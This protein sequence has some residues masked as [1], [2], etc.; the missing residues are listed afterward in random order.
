LEGLGKLFPHLNVLKAGVS[1]DEAAIETG[2][3]AR[4][5]RFAGRTSAPVYAG[6]PEGEPQAR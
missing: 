2:Y 3:F 1:D 6:E 4:R 5:A